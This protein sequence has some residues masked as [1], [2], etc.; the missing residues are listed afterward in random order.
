MTPTHGHSRVTARFSGAR[1]SVDRKPLFHP[2]VRAQPGKNVMAEVETSGRV[3]VRPDGGKRS[4][5]SN[6]LIR[7]CLQRHDKQTNYLIGVA[8]RLR[9]PAPD[10]SVETPQVPGQ[11]S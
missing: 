7:R 9:R 11:L 8:C 6:P 4:E 10:R 3:D 2:E 5:L 1:R